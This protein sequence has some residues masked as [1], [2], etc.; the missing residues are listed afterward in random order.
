M[1]FIVRSINIYIQNILVKSIRFLRAKKNIFVWFFPALINFSAGRPF[2]KKRILVLYDLS[3]QPFSIGDILIMQEAALILKEEFGAELVDF[4]LLYDFSSSLNSDIAFKDI[5]PENAINNLISLLPVAQVNPY[6]G[7]IF[8][9]NHRKQLEK[10]ISDNIKTYYVWPSGWAFEIRREY[11]YYRIFDEIIYPF[12]KR[13]GRIPVLSARKPLEKW[14][15]NFFNKYCKDSIPVTVN[16]R[17]NPK[18][19]TSRNLTIEHWIEFFSKCEN[20]YNTKFIIICA[21][22]EIDERLRNCRNVLIAKDFSTNI[23]QDLALIQCSA[24]HLGVPSGP[25]TVAFFSEKPYIIFKGELHK[26][27]FKHSDMVSLSSDGVQ[28]FC[29]AGD[30]QLFIGGVESSS[31]MLTEFDKIYCSI[32]HESWRLNNSVKEAYIEIANWLR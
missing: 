7:S 22:S 29:F 16:L 26:Q 30:S 11:L 13:N 12:Y 3:T 25:A 19:Q 4:A 8:A 17:N 15:S 32:N 21:Q 20:I 27:F 1:T 10:F 5:A 24:I 14:A 28:K 9:F 2:A 31:K 18:F 23:E 6:I